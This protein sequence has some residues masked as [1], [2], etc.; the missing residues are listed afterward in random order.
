M[1]LR[2]LV[3]GMFSAIIDDARDHAREILED[4]PKAVEVLRHLL[5]AEETF[6]NALDDAPGAPAAPTVAA[7][8][9][10]AQAPVQPAAD[11]A[12]AVD[13]DAVT[14][15]GPAGTVHAADELAD[16]SAAP[17]LNADT[18]S[19]EGSAP[20]VAAPMPGA[21]HPVTGPVDSAPMPGADVPVTHVPAE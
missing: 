4:H 1:D 18:E 20:A 5:A 7:P 2:K 10:G 15:S 13:P 17:D 3:G 14:D 6:L 16:D 21:D 11:P 9:I 8:E 12:P 19:A